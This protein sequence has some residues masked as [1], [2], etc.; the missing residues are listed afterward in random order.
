VAIDASRWSR[1]QELFHS[2]ADRPQEIRMAELERLAIDEP[3]VARE[4]RGMLLADEHGASMLDRGVGSAASDVLRPAD[5]LPPYKFGPYRIVRLLGEGGMGVVYLGHRDD[6]DA[7]AAIKILSHAWLSPARQERFRNETQT[8]AALDH[9]SVARLLDADHLPDGTPWFAMEYVEGDAITTWVW[10]RSLEIRPLLELFTDV[11]DA[12]QHAHER[13]VIHRDI[14]PSNVLV[15][16]SGAIKLLDF[17][18]A[19]RF[20]ETLAADTRSRTAFRMLTPQYAAPEQLQGGLVGVSADVYALGVMLFELIAGRRPYDLNDGDGSD[21]VVAIR[22]AYPPNVR[23]AVRATRDA[24]RSAAA[25]A[26]DESTTSTI[27]LASLSASEWTDLDA[28]LSTALAPDPGDRYRSVEAFRGDIQRFLAQEPLAARTATWTYRARKFI[29]RRWRGVAVGSAALAAAALALLLHTRTLTA[30]RDVAIAEAART[31]RLQQFL[32]DLFQG[33]PQGVV[34]G[35]SLRLTT[36]VQ[37]GIRETRGLSHDTVTQTELLGTLGII[38]EQIGSFRQADSLFLEAIQR[39]D[40]RYGANHP[41]SIRARIRRA[42]VLTRLNKTD[43]AELQ[44]TALAAAARRHAPPD[45]PA[46]A[47][48]NEALGKLLGES[49]KIKEALPL[50]ELAVAQRARA[51]TMSREYANALR[52]LGNATAYAGQRERADSIWRR[53]LPILQRL[54]GPRHPNAGFLLTNLGTVA[55]MMGNLDVAERD[56]REGAEISAGWFGPHHWLTAGARMPLAQTLIRKKQFAEAAVVLREVIED[57]SRDPLIGPDNPS[58]SLARNA[59]GHALVGLGDRNGA[60][61]AF[62]EAAVKLRAT[63]GPDHMNTLLDEA[64]LAGVLIDD[65]AIDSAIVILRS[66]IV[67]GS[68]A[69]GDAHPEIAGFRLKLGRALLRAHKPQEAIEV[70]SAGLRVADSAMTGRTEGSRT[71]IGVLAS[72]YEA[73]G[74]TAKAATLRRVVSA[75]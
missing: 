25:V 71:A 54:Y 7:R 60:R 73:I 31:T 1:I 2:L 42:A 41:E 64:S 66:T 28:L 56:L 3:D 61:Q 21:P 29:R 8:L 18:I 9:P 6:V 10:K 20:R 69:Y 75:R 39:S 70:T 30:A 27:T 32:V 26:G 38:S 17:G 46:V 50:L 12:V 34:A 5:A 35:D 53:A 19:K 59:L 36:V 13:A 63:L 74:D 16:P 14:K 62:E 15:T 55:S 43:S 44:L 33:G 23:R 51:D 72:A 68:K 22:A 65:D 48:V 45:H 40:A 52:E 47:E 49:G 4:V 58:V 57:E 11:C 67:R 24:H 37:N